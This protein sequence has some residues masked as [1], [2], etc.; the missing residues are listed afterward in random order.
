MGWTTRILG[1]G[2]P[3]LLA[4]A[5]PAGAKDLRPGLLQAL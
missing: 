3:A 5:A 2:F 1:F 4:L